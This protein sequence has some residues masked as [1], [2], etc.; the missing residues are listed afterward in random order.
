MIPQEIAVE[1]VNPW[2]VQP[3]VIGIVLLFAAVIVPLIEELF[4]PI[5]VLAVGRLQSEPSSRFCRWCAQWGG[6]LLSRSLML[7]GTTEQW[8]A[9][10]L[11][12]VGTSAVHIL[13]AA[14]TGWALVRTWQKNAD[15]CGYCLCISWPF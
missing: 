6:M 13:T 10:V 8:S 2:L 11:A 7:S 12:R 3:A 4:K 9:A 15:I 14:L 5:G 1:I